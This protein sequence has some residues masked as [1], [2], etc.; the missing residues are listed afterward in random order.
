GG[1]GGSGVGPPGSG[2]WCLGS[3]MSAAHGSSEFVTCCASPGGRSGAIGGWVATGGTDWTVRL[4][5][6]VKSRELGRLS[7][8]GHSHPV[9][10]LACSSDGNML[11]SGGEDHKVI[12]WSPQSRRPLATLKGHAST[13]HGLAIDPGMHSGNPPRWI[14]SGG[15]EGFLLIWD[16]RNW[17]SPVATLLGEV[18]HRSPADSTLSGAFSSGVSMSERHQEGSLTSGLAG[19]RLRGESGRWEGETTGAT[20]LNSVNCLA[21]GGAPGGGEWLFA[22]GETIV[23]SWQRKDGVWHGGT[24]LPGDDL[25]G[26]ASLSAVE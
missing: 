1:T 6:V 4:W 22:G 2:R 14:A 12:V 3:T 11:V 16:P 20:M 21:A 13:V 15:G 25:G 23:R 5:D 10:S 19:A 18:D 9:R 8:M 24:G 17:A 7:F 26:V